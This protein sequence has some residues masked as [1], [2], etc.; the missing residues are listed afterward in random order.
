MGV[1]TD[2]DTFEKIIIFGGIQNEVIKDDAKAIE[3]S[4]P[5]EKTQSQ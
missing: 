5:D 4:G 2:G 1:I 3:E